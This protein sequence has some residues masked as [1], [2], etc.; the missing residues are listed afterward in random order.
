MSHFKS[1]I[2]VNLE[3]LAYNYTYLKNYAAKNCVI[4][5]AVKANAYGTGVQAVSKKLVELGCRDF[6]VN[7]LDE[8]LEVKHLIQKNCNIYILTGFDRDGYDEIRQNNFIP[9]IFNFSQLEFLAK[10]PIEKR[11]KFCINF[12]TGMKRMGFHAKD[13]IK[14]REVALQ[15]NLLDNLMYII[16]HLGSAEDML[17]DRN[18]N[19]YIKFQH[20][21]T[22]F[23]QCK[24]SFSNSAGILLNSK[25][26]THLVRPGAYLYGICTSPSIDNKQKIVISKYGQVLHR[27]IADEDSLISYGSTY[28]VKKGQKVF[29]ILMGYADG[30]PRSASNKAY[31]GYA[32]KHLKI[33]GN[34]TMDMTMLDASSLTDK[35]FASC[36]FVE[37]FG[38]NI[39][40]EDI[41]KISGTIAY[42][43]LTGTG[44]RCKY[45][46]V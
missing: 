7:N 39:K 45:E 26:H 14:V 5:A 37:V 41:A 17:N 4:G 30:Y 16:S 44:K 32:G 42:E 15:N 21:K 27:Y 46:Y 18:E 19:Q 24:F 8:A 36:N 2:R 1:F 31:M 9:I 34:I 35:E 23:P 13:A 25:Y 40:I 11:C 12:D 28:A 38:E 33:I 6:F 10:L 29:T 20:I 43:M 22:Y 3:N